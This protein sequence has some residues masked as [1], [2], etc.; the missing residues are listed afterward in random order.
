MSDEPKKRKRW[1]WFVGPPCVVLAIYVGGYFRLAEHP[2][3]RGTP[4]NYIRVYPW[5]WIR[6]AYVPLAW[7]DAHLNN[8]LVV[9]QTPDDDQNV[10]RG[11][12]ID[13]D[14]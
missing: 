9:L 11:I 2:L 12:W 5:N 13:P 4:L 14:E 6:L 1:R 7:I 10:F 3:L 8:R